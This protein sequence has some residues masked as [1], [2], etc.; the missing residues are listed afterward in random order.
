[1]MADYRYVVASLHIGPLVLTIAWE[2]GEILT[3]SDLLI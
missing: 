1:M 2:F 3:I